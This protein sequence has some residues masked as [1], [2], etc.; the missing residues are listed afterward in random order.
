[1]PVRL[2]GVLGGEV[3]RARPHPVVAGEFLELAQQVGVAGQAACLEQVGHHRDV[4][5][6]LANALGETAHA[7]ADLQPRIPQE[8]DQLLG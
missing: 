8:C 5:F 2:L 3:G 6:G 1:M 4:G 7:V